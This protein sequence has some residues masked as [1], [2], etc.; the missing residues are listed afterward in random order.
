MSRFGLAKDERV[1]KTW[2]YQEIMRRGLR[3]S[4]P[5]FTLIFYEVKDAGLRLGLTVSKKVG[6]AHDR[7]RVKRYIR[8][9]FRLN[10]ETIIEGL[11]KNF[12]TDN[13]GFK[14]VFRAKPGAALLSH[15]E[16]DEEFLLLIKKMINFRFDRG[17]QGTQKKT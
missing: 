12:D 11:K 10:K 3:V 5:H 13:F 4:A 14:L 1:R 15:D 6:K 2:E 7:N 16:M 8:E 9:F 17:K